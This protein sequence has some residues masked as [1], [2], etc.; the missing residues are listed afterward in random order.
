MKKRNLWL[1]EKESKTTNF[2]YF[3]DVKEPETLTQQEK[4]GGLLLSQIAIQAKV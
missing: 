4:D 1:V 3:L 2:V